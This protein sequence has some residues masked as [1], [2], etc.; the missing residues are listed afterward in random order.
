[1][2][3]GSKIRAE[4]VRTAGAAPA[5]STIQQILARRTGSARR[6]VRDRTKPAWRRFVRPVSNDLWQIDAT[7]HTLRDE[8]GFWVVDILDDHSRF[9]LAARVGTGP[10][11]ALAW[12]ALTAAVAAYGLPR[13]LLSDNGTTFTG[14]LLGAEVGFERCV[15][16]P[17]SSW[18]MPGRATPRPWASSSVSTAPRT[19]GS[20]IT[21]PELC[22]R[23]STSS[24]TTAATTTA[25]GHTTRSMAADPP[26]CT[27]P[28]HCPCHPGPGRP[29]AA[30]TER[31]S[32]AHQHLSPPPGIQPPLGRTSPRRGGAAI[33]AMSPVPRG[34]GHGLPPASAPAFATGAF[35]VDP[36][37]NRQPRRAMSSSRSSTVESLRS[38]SWPSSLVTQQR[39][40]PTRSA[41]STE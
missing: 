10:T 30:P 28:T 21:G 24:T 14:R 41:V 35:R 17:A 18:S 19:S 16:R 36:H 2:G 7:R 20:T 6:R 1:M 25:T 39:R 4:L 3:P 37:A 13:Q 11:G 9:L 40:L 23:P 26:T 32:P 12:D 27:G 38:P 31:Q 33:A 5:R 34:F 22:P 29:A 15:G 8:T